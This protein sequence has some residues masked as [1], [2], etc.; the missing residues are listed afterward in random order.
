MTP[1]RREA[2]TRAAIVGAARDM[3][4]TTELDDLSLRKLAS[5]LGVTAPA[6][7]AHVEDKEDLLQAVAETG[8]RDLLTRLER[9]SGDPLERLRG[10]GRAYVEQALADPEVFRVMFLYR[11]AALDVPGVD[12]ALD[13]A[14]EAFSRPDEAVREAIAVGAIHPDRD[15]ARVALVLWTTAHG[16]ATVLLLG[17]REG[18]VIVPE[19]MDAL[20]DDVLDVTLAGL[21]L[22]PGAGTDA[23]VGQ[24]T[25]A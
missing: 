20:V 5:T 23:P 16:C 14:T 7:Y 4:R 11:P 6:L 21:A 13:A 2:L 12:N 25:S 9:V 10:Y 8:F 18:E 15:P 19:G 17:A 22:P 24:S 1:P 3:L